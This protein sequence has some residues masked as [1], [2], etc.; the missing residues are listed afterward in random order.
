MDDVEDAVRDARLGEQRRQVVG[1][2]GILLGRLEHERVARRDGRREHPHRHHRREVERRDAGH[3]PQRLADLVDVDPARDLLGEA[4]LQEARDA[5]REFEVLETAGDLAERVRRDL[6]VLGGQVGGELL[7]VGLDQVPDPEHDL[8]PLR[9]RGCAPGRE[10]CLRGGDSGAD[11]VCRGEVHVARDPTRGGVVDRAFTPRG[12]GDQPATDPVADPARCL[13][14]CCGAAWFCDLCHRDRPLRGND[15][16][17]RSSQ[18]ATSRR[19]RQNRARVSGSGQA[20]STDPVGRPRVGLG[21]ATGTTDREVDER[22]E[23]ADRDPDRDQPR[24]GQ[25]GGLDRV[26]PGGRDERSSD[27]PQAD[28]GEEQPP[29]TAPE[30]P[31][32][33]RHG[34]RGQDRQRRD[35]LVRLRWLRRQRRGRANPTAPDRDRRSPSLRGWAG[36]GQTPS[37]PSSASRHR[38]RT[39]PGRRPGAATGRSTPRGGS[40]HS[41]PVRNPPTTARPRSSPPIDGSRSWPG[42]EP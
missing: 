12:P 23:A 11:L 38:A 37:A 7:A 17:T 31:G 13:R 16:D 3:D 2:R 21:R 26:T 36:P 27:R 4:A 24:G 15:H 18:G 25:S 40:P 30:C 29:V 20:T 28:G 41:S 10:G 8:G 35:A 9:D 34:Q 33:Q 19:S 39:G 22:D 14:L 6:A 32:H 5:A 1:R 42:A